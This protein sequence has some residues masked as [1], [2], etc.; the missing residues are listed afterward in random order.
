MVVLVLFLVCALLCMQSVAIVTHGPTPVP[1]SSSSSATAVG[2]GIG[3]GVGVLV[4]GAVVYW[5]LR[6][7]PLQPSKV[8]VT[9]DVET[10]IGLFYWHKTATATTDFVSLPRALLCLVSGF[11]VVRVRGNAQALCSCPSLRDF[12]CRVQKPRRGSR[13][14]ALPARSKHASVRVR[15]LSLCAIRVYACI[16][17]VGA[18]RG[19]G[20]WH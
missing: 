18:H 14:N 8:K 13:P 5:R 16:W 4:V 6:S 10:H 2:V 19:A 3:V 7:K 12:A 1:S 20:R 15:R 17:N 9:G 11:F